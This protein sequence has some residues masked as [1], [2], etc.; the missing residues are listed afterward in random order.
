MVPPSR[1]ATT[2]FESC[3]VPTQENDLATPTNETTTPFLKGG[4]KPPA[5]TAM[6]PNDNKPEKRP[7][8]PPASL[9]RPA[10]GSLAS[11]SR[12]ARAPPARLA[13]P[14]PEAPQRRQG[15]EVRVGSEVRQAPPLLLRQPQPPAGR[16]LAE[17]L[18]SGFG[19]KISTPWLRR[20]Y[21]FKTT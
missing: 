14:G 8:P 9:A 16:P 3:L 20:V 17:R 4:T 2:P 12:L 21:K 18:V 13:A 11:R 5:K 7:A 6:Q 19:G 15:P 10:R 1:T